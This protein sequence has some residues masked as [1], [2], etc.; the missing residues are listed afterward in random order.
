M[1]NPA[2]VYQNQSITTANPGE[3]T[4]MLYNG[5]IKFL[6]QAQ[7]ALKDN[8][9]NEAHELIMKVQDIVQELMISLNVDIPISEEFMRLYDFMHHR[10]VEANMKKDAGLLEEVEYFFVQF[11]DTWKETMLKA[12]QHEVSKV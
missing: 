2:Q 5:G 8:Q 7:L 12:K 4:L 11:R 6:K 10:L 1:R 3:L 9:I